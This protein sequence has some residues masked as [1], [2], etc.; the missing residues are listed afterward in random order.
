MASAITFGDA[1]DPTFVKGIVHGETSVFPEDLRTNLASRYANYVE[2]SADG[3]LENTFIVSS[4]APAVAAF[5]RDA[6]AVRRQGGGDLHAF[7]TYNVHPSKAS[8]LRQAAQDV[9]DN[10]LAHPEMS[11]WNQLMALVLRFGQGSLHLLW[12]VVLR[13][14]F[15]VQGRHHGRWWC[16]RRCVHDRTTRPILLRLVHDTGEL[17][18]Q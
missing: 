10:T 11:T 15:G 9:V 14:A 12:A 7:V 2:V 4:W 5:R 13:G 1:R 6:G 16:P 17:T 18:L 8:S 3:S